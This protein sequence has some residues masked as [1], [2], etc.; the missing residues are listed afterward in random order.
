[1]NKISKM[2]CPLATV[3]MLL[4]APMAQAGG[5]LEHA[6]L[7]NVNAARVANGLQP[8]RY[9]D[10]LDGPSALRAASSNILFAHKRPDGRE[11]K[12]AFAPQEYDWFGENLAVSNVQDAGKIVQAWMNSPT[13]RANLL[14]R[15]FTQMAV[16][17]VKGNDGHFYWA[18]F[19]ASD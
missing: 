19:L 14:N 15:H 1:M 2:L 8:L 18:Q 16:A 9:C 10:A 17:S 5:A 11:V 6:V 4:M 3:G 13:H 12:T 7:T